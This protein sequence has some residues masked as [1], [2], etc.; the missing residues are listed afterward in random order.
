MKTFREYMNLAGYSNMKSLSNV[1]GIP[2]HLISDAACGRYD[3]CDPEGLAKLF[4]V[5]GYSFDNLT[6]A[7][8]VNYRD[9]LAKKQARQAEIE[10]RL[11]R[12][13]EKRN[14]STQSEPEESDGG[15]IDML[16]YLHRPLPKC[17]QGLPP[18]PK[19]NYAQRWKVKRDIKALIAQGKATHELLIQIE[20]RWKRE[21]EGGQ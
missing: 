4:E 3:K 8:L 6:E 10:K 12:I 9:R 11:R 21:R 2:Y 5:I 1:T 18:T 7:Q 19:M 20:E 16:T 14:R 13:E 15:E 17:A